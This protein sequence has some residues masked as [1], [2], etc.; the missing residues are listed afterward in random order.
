MH[1][2]RF[3]FFF[4]HEGLFPL[5]GSVFVAGNLWQQKYYQLSTQSSQTVAQSLPHIEVSLFSVLFINK[6]L[7]L[8]QLKDN[9]IEHIF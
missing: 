3:F 7:L 2:A 6:N 5:W 4:S 1:T 9:D 8:C